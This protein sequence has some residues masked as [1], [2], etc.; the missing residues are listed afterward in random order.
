MS[1]VPPS[2]PWATTRTSS[3]PLTF[4]AAGTAAIPL[5]PYG[6]LGL[7]PLT[8]SV[9]DVDTLDTVAATKVDAL[10]VGGTYAGVRPTDAQLKAMFSVSGGEPSTSLQDNPSGIGWTFNSGSEA[11]DA[12]PVGETLILTYTVRATDNNGAFDDQPVTITITGTNDLPVAVADT[13]SVTEDAAD[14]AGLDDGNAFTSIV[15]GNHYG[16][17]QYHPFYLAR[18]GEVRFPAPG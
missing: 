3:R 12:I 8:L 1:V 18:V 5:P 17:D 2:P 13:N 11:F 10:T 15:G 6:I 7:D 4:I 9:F 14:Q 16:T